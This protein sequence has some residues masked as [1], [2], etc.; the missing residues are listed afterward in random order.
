[1]SSKVLIPTALKPYAQ[2]QGSVELHGEN[3]GE[4]LENLTE[5][6]PDIKKHLFSEDGKIR[7]FVNVY[8]NDDDIRYLDQNETKLKEGD[9][10]SIVPSV[11]GGSLSGEL[12]KAEMERYSRHLIMPEFGMD[13]QKKLRQASVLLIGAGGLGA[14]S[15]MYLA[16]AGVGRRRIARGG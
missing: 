9:V 6:F 11:A 4:I 3:V 2:G 12:S 10:V 13:G 14:P 5:T 15:S 8:V 16:A 7:N 1:M